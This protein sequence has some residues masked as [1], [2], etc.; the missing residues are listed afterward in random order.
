MLTVS[1]KSQTLID[2]IFKCHLNLEKMNVDSWSKDKN[3]SRRKNGKKS[4][5]WLLVRKSQTLTFDQM[6]IFPFDQS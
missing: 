6:T 1:L 4:N 2:N 5:Y 3:Y